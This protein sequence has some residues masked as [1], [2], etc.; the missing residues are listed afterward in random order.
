V[1]SL[2][3]QVLQVYYE[4]LTTVRDIFVKEQQQSSVQAKLDSFFKPE[5]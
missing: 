4:Y 1:I 3:T 5:L 2:T